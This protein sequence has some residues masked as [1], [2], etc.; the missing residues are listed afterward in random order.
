MDQMIPLRVDGLR[1]FR[2]AKYPYSADT[3]RSERVRSGDTLAGQGEQKPALNAKKL[4]SFICGYKGL[5]VQGHFSFHHSFFT[6]M[7]IAFSV[8]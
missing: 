4:G 1:K 2:K 6:A 7:Y 3:A 8:P 5:L